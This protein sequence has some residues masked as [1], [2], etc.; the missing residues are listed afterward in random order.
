M[1]GRRRKA[2]HDSG[3]GGGGGGEG[4]CQDLTAAAAVGDL[5]LPLLPR[6]KFVWQEGFHMC[7]LIWEGGRKATPDI[8]RF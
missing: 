8:M 5:L 1:F 3:G 4:D 7:E 2:N 6:P